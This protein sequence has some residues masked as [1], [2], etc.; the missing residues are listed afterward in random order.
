MHPHE[1]MLHG[2]FAR[3]GAGEIR[4]I[5]LFL[6]ECKRAGLLDRPP[7]EPS[8]GV[9]VIPKEVPMDLGARLVRTAGPRWIW[10]YTPD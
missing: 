1:A 2:A 9:V 6:Q 5:K 4:A 10:T 7:A 8:S 3:V